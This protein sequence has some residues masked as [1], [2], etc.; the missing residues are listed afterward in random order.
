VAKAGYTYEL[1]VFAEDAF[2]IE[3]YVV[4]ASDGRPVGTV[5]GLLRRHGELLLAVER[6]GPPGMH[7]RRV[8]RWL[9]VGEVDH[10]ALAVWLRLPAERLEAADQLD[11]DALRVDGEAEARRVIDLPPDLAPR[12]EVSPPGPVDRP[13]VTLL[14]VVGGAVAFGVLV[15]VAAATAFQT[16]WVY[17][18]FVVPAVL[19]AVAAAVA[20]R[21]W[22]R[23]YE[24]R[25]AQK[26]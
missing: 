12:P 16:P 19:A 3:D 23:P 25:G 10:E 8:V 1:R 13:V 24:S 5:A 17:L 14:P 7:D 2:G 11:P 18:G 15:V 20:L 4:R 6:D 26:P 21:A 22:R 9:E